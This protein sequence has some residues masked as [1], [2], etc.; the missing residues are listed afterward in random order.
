MD[1]TEMVIM[2]IDVN[3]VRVFDRATNV[4]ASF[5]RTQLTV[6]NL[7]EIRT[8]LL[9]TCDKQAAIATPDASAARFTSAS[10]AAIRI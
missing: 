8:L 5:D 1:E 4:I 2:T 10:D 3:H 6:E 9:T 7:R